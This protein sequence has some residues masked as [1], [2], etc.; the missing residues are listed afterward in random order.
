MYTPTYYV[1]FAGMPVAKAIKLD[2][3]ISHVHTTGT[4]LMC[5]YGAQAKKFVLL[6]HRDYM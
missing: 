2:A 5:V 3:P 4:H 6:S 1:L